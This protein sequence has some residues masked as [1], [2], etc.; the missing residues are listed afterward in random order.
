MTKEQRAEYMRKWNAEHPG[1]AKERLRQWRAAN[2][3]KSKEYTRQWRLR[4]PEKYKAHNIATNALPSKPC[5]ICGQKGHRHHSDYSRPLYVRYLCD[6][7]HKQLHREMNE[8]ATLTVE[9]N[10]DNNETSRD[11]ALGVCGRV[12]ALLRSNANS[13]EDCA[14]ANEA[15]AMVKTKRDARRI[16]RMGEGKPKTFLDPVSGRRVPANESERAKEQRRQAGI[17]SGKARREKL[18]RIAGEIASLQN[19][20]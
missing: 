3:D 20:V 5:E 2:P 9:R 16:G 12:D 7:H 10:Y 15:A 1:H 18:A 6:K 17:A 4:N 8:S 19:R 13:G 14:R 11:C